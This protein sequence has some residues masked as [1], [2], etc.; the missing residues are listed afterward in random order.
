MRP[1][2]LLT[3]LTV[4]LASGCNN[5]GIGTRLFD[6]R[7]DPI[8]VIIPAG[9]Q[10]GVQWVLGIDRFPARFLN[11][12]RDAGVTADE[13]DAVYGSRA[14]L[15][16]LTGEDFRQI[17]GL[18]IRACPVG[19]PGGCDPLSRVFSMRDLYGRRQAT[20]DINP[21]PPNLRDLF[22]T[23]ELIRVEFIVIPGETTNRTIEARLEWSVG[24]FGFE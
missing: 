21:A 19:S 22:L 13:I 18:E 11:E 10:A 24:A 23:D 15:T 4:L 9:Q 3:T 5:D 2:F 8:N 1:N 16:S 6:V 17:E 20:I 7:Y 14:R 12:M